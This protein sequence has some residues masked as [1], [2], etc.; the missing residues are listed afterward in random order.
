MGTA[1]CFRV[2]L[3]YTAPMATI[4]DVAEAAGCSTATVSRAL[5]SPEKVTEVTRQRVQAAIARVGYAP[6]LAARNLRRSESR[7]IVVLLPDIANP[8]FSE[9]IAGL[10][11]TAHQAGYQVLLGDCE[12]DAG[13]AEAYFGLLRTNQADGLILLTSEVPQALVRRQHTDVPVVTACEYFDDIALPTVRIDNLQAAVKAVDYLLSLGHRRI[14]TL[15]GPLGNP[16]CRDRNAGFSH[17][18][19]QAGLEPKDEWVV[20]GDFSFHAGY[21]NGRWLLRLPRQERP[22]A[23]FCHSDEMAIGLM[24]AARDAGIPVPD[25]LSVIG[26][27]NIGFSEYC[28]P[29]LT[30]VSQPRE[31]IGRTAMQTL[32]AMLHK[33]AV[34]PLQVLNT[35]LIV[36]E[37]T[38]AVPERAP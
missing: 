3:V 23:V 11:E 12:H 5:A 17:Q 29:E 7:T 33:Q 4:K 28:E 24:K 9:I 31:Q 32:L 25:E 20:A 19:R 27:D 18:L 2:E 34:L 21:Q 36:R 6:N 26:F 16:I 1:G 35:Q 22:T 13:R 14:A 37:S 38:A 30:T 10:E 15:S 8:F